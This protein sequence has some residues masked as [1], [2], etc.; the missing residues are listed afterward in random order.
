M[1]E[2]MDEKGSLPKRPLGKTGERIPVLGLGGEG[3]L[4]TFERQKEAVPLIHRAIEL[5]VTY[6]E[7]ARAYSGSESY[8][9]MALRER[10]KDIFLASKSHERTKDGAIKHLETTLSNMKTH[11]LDLWMVHDVRTPKHLDH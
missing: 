11:F 3:V 1:V 4:R 2:K 5:G 7:S 10:R 9:G 8:Y 6:F